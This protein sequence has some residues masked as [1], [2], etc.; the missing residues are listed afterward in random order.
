[1]VPIRFRADEGRDI[2]ALGG[3]IRRVRPERRRKR[4]MARRAA[5]LARAGWRAKILHQ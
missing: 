2:L 4:M 3:R 1:M 5:D